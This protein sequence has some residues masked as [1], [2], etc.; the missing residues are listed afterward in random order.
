M[1]KENKLETGRIWPLI[2]SLAIPSI[3]AQLVGI[4]YN[5]VDRM[6]IGRIEDGT[7]AMAALSVSLPLIT[8][9]TAFTR[10]LGIG[11]A[12]TCAIRMGQRDQ[13]GAE[14]ILGVSFASLLTAGAVITAVILLFKR[15]L[16][17]LFGA[18]EAIL[19]LACDYMGIYSLGTVF[20]MISLGMNSYITTQGFA[21]TGMCTVLIGAFL[22]IVFDALFIR[23]LH[24]GV[25][26]AAIATV[27]AQ[28]ISCAW[29]LSFLFG[30]KSLL[31]MRRKYF[32]VKWSVLKP[33]MALGVSPFTMSMT[34]SLIQI[35][36]NNQLAKFGGTMAVSTVAI[37][38]SLWQFMTLPIQG[39][40]QGSQPNISF[41]YGAQKFSRVRRACRISLGLC[42]AYAVILTL[43]MIR[44]PYRFAGIF[45]NDERLLNLCAWALPIYIAGGLVFGAQ[46]SFQQ[47]FVSLGQAR[48]SLLLACLRKVILLTPLLYMFPLTVA[49][50]PMAAVLSQEAAGLVFC[51]PEVFAVFL[52]EPVSDVAASV[53]TTLV[54]VWFYFKY[55][56][57]PDRGSV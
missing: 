57:R 25:R 6:F 39:L 13:D 36:F 26:G 19:G 52:A 50:L 3:I 43:L 32:R 48:I 12:P 56:G 22:N 10:L 9:I 29:A 27:I 54:F 14:E 17:T 7:S 44:F 4:L 41:N 40:F 20:V 53:C 35:S 55:L 23:G 11:G 28:G 8:C 42:M 18:D 15:P 46:T 37:L 24:M 16:L 45:T 33:I 49:K 31:K 1:E 5:M 34:E 21:R 2:L 30:P 38:F 47:S 51:P